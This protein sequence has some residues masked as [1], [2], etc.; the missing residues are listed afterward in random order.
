MLDW[1]SNT[2]FHENI[3]IGKPATSFYSDLEIQKVKELNYLDIELYNYIKS[4]FDKFSN[5]AIKRIHV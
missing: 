1:E 2:E 5:N 3:S 4:N